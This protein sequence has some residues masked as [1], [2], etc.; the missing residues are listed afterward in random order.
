M[1]HVSALLTSIV[2]TFGIIGVGWFCRKVGIWDKSMVRGL[3]SYAYY[4]AL[5]ALIFHS[6]VVSK[7]A[8]R[9]SK[10]DLT[11]I[12]GV[13]GAH[14]LLAALAFLFV[15]GRRVLKETRTAALML[16]T[17]GST[18]YVGDSVCVEHLWN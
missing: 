11:L 13:L 1:T 9:F 2:P 3:N 17:F 14:F 10:D 18:A 5:P 16:V 7:F 4:I 15:R 12:G 6:L 8:A